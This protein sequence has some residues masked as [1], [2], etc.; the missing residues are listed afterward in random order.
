MNIFDVQTALA[1]INLV[2]V[3][4]FASEIPIARQ[5]ISKLRAEIAG[6]VDLL[7]QVS[8]SISAA[9]ERMT[10]IELCYMGVKGKSEL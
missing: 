2:D 10:E 9:Q 4:K 6:L 3:E 1:K 5:E 8:D 7:K